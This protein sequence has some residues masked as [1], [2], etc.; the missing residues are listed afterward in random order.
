M[1]SAFS[2]YRA[3]QKVPIE[4]IEDVTDKIRGPSFQSYINKTRVE[5][6]DTVSKSASI[7]VVKL[8]ANNQQVLRWKKGLPSIALSYGWL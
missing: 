8:C 4:S 5:V 3:K 1:L 6:S 7:F 2:H